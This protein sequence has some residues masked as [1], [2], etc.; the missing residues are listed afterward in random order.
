MAE[1]RFRFAVVADTH[2]R[3]EA[4]D[5]SSPWEVNKLANGRCRFVAALVKQMAPAFT[6][7]LGDVVHP[8]PVLPSYHGAAQAALEIFADLGFQ[9]YRSRDVE[10]D[11]TNFELLNMPPHHP[12]RDMWDTFHTTTP[13]VLLRTHTSPGQIRVMRE[14]CPE[15]IRVILPGMCYRYEQ[16]TARAD[17][18][19]YQMEGLAVGRGIT[20]ANLKATLADFARRMFGPTVRTR[21][22]AEQVGFIFQQFHLIPYL[23]ALENVLMPCT[24]NENA[25][26]LRD[27]GFCSVDPFFRWYNWAAFLAVKRTSRA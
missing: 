12:A 24:V 7:H 17:V 27:V 20:L 25:E 21:F 26:L 10:D 23:S 16:I 14:F 4:G 18:Q 15:P 11:L 3:P 13:G 8:V 22:R 19:F 1:P 2:T 6:I 5:L 9:I